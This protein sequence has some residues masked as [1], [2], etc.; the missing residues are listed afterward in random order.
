[1]FYKMNLVFVSLLM[2]LYLA[3]NGENIKTQTQ[4]QLVLYELW[5]RIVLTFGYF[6][7]PEHKE[8]DVSFCDHN[9]S[10][11][12]RSSLRPSSIFWTEI[13]WSNFMKFSWNVDLY[14]IYISVTKFVQIRAPQNIIRKIMKK[15]VSLRF[16]PSTFN[17]KLKVLTP[18]HWG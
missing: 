4:V 3:C 2:F 16:E 11:V 12:H 7:S 1:M 6:S 17:L 8:L 13:T 10:T 14:T 5:N 18:Y 15:N 9:F